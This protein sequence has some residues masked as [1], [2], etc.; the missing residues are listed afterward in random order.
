MR[1]DATGRTL[2]GTAVPYGVVAEVSDGYGTYRERF[3][4]AAFA[5]SIA[6]RGHKVRI[7]IQHETR[8]L[9][10]GKATELREDSTGLHAAFMLARTRDADEALELV[11]DEIVDGFSVGFRPIRDERDGDVTVR[12]E[13]ALNEVS[14]VHSPAYAG[15]LV[16]GVRSA[17]PLALSVEVA[18]RRLSFILRDW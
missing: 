16:A 1:A 2:H 3:A 17:S 9:P 8:R 14:L 7:F 15:A 10:I 5:R 6:E 12:L 13:A 11:R 4:P 18:S